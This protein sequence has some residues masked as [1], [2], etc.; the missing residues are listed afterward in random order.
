MEKLKIRLKRG[1]FVSIVK[2]FS[3]GNGDMFYIKHENNTV[4]IIDCNLIEDVKDVILDEIEDLVSDV[5]IH[6]FISTH[7]DKDHITGLKDLD[8]RININNFYCVNNEI[9]SDSSDDFNAY[10]LLRD[11]EKSF[12]LTKECSRKWLN[13]SGEDSNGTYIVGSGISVLWPEISNKFFK[14]ELEKINNDEKSSNNI[15]PIIKYSL[16]NGV[17]ILWFGDI[18]NDFLEKISSELMNIQADIVFAP[19]HG[20]KTGKIPRE[21]LKRINPS[22]IIIGEAESENLNYYE[23]YNTITQNSVKDIVLNCMYNKVHIHTNK[24]FKSSIL[25]FE[26]DSSFNNVKYRGTLNL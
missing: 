19:H 18:E 21:I 5:K 6:R 4:T 3:V 1:V 9:K 20:R 14:E 24:P 8:E 12:Y 25:S 11:G 15:S 22:L 10:C 7:P 13:D 23:N 16:E 26:S 2:S 17:K